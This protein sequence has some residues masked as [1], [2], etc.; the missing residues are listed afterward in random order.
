MPWKV[1]SCKEFT[2]TSCPALFPKATWVTLIILI[3]IQM[4]QAKIKQLNLLQVDNHSLRYHPSWK[5]SYLRLTANHKL[6]VCDNW[7]N[8]QILSSVPSQQGSRYDE[9]RRDECKK[10][11][12]TLEGQRPKMVGGGAGLMVRRQRAGVG[13][14]VDVDGRGEEDTWSA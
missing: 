14:R 7:S 4:F 9:S 5:D 11:E 1:N 10:V 12:Q 13:R 8:G 6:V 2:A 3:E